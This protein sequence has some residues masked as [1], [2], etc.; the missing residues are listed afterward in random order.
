MRH[1]AN[2]EYK[3]T[4]AQGTGASA[5]LTDMYTWFLIKVMTNFQRTTHS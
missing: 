2:V 4:A 1:S 5:Y 3:E